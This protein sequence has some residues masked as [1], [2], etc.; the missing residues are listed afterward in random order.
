MCRLNRSFFVVIVLLLAA[1]YVSTFFFM[2]K[3]MIISGF[4]YI[5]QFSTNSTVNALLVDIWSPL[6]YLTGG[7][8]MSK[9][10]RT[11]DHNPDSKDHRPVYVE[12]F[13]PGGTFAIDHWNYD[14]GRPVE[15]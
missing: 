3:A 13:D 15:W 4:P 10:R 2:R 9:W 14:T 1:L 12:T 7:Q 8:R 11:I 6:I 5:Y